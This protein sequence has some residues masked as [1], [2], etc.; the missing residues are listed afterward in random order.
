MQTNKE[1][2]LI[3]IYFD[4]NKMNVWKEKCVKS[5][6]YIIEKIKSKKDEIDKEKEKIRNEKNTNILHLKNE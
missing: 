4:E 6:E 2:V 3:D 1:K 5:S